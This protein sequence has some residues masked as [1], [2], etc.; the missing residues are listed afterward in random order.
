M[1][2]LII[3]M[4][5]GVIHSIEADGKGV[6]AFVIDEDKE[7]ASDNNYR[8]LLWPG[9]KKGEEIPRIAFEWG[10]VDVSKRT[11]KTLTPQIEDEKTLASFCQVCLDDFLQNRNDQRPGWGF[12]HL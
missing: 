10:R 6:Q 11:V 8:K 3:F 4:S 5:G 7:G 1:V 12:L 2:K 9:D